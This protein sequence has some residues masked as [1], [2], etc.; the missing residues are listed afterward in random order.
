MA[1][2]SVKD[3]EQSP[4][5]GLSSTE[6]RRRLYEFGPNNIAAKYAP[7]WR[8][9]AAKFWGPIPWLLEFAILLQ[10]TLGKYIEATVIGALL[11]F[12]ATLG[13]VQEGRASTALAALRK[14]LAPM[15]PV[16]RDGEWKRLVASDVVPGD[17]IRLTLGAMIPADARLVSGSLLLDQSAI[18][19]ESVPVDVALGDP[20]HAG[21][22]VRRGEAQAEVTATGGRTAYGR[23]AELVRSARA[24]S[25]EQLAIMGVTRSLI[26]VNGCVAV[27]IVVGATMLGLPLPDLVSLALTG[28]LAS[29]PA[30]L[31]ATFT[32]SAA[33]S[34]QVLAKQGV[35]LTRLS[36]AHEAA[37]MDLLCADKTGTLTR[38]VLEV[39]EIVPMPG[40]D[41]A[42]LLALAAFASSEADQDPIDT[43]IRTAAVREAAKPDHERQLRFVPFDPVTRVAEALIAD[44]DGIES[45]VSKG[46][47]EAISSIAAVSPEALQSANELA[48]RGHRVIAVAA[49]LPGESRLCGL[50]AISDPPREE[51]ALLVGALSE[52]GVRTV[53]VT[54]DSPATATAIA[55]KVGIGGKTCPP[56]RLTAEQS[57]DAYDIFARVNPD[58]KHRLVQS[59]QRS[60]HVVGMCGDGL[61]D[62]PALRQA[63]IG[64][65][66]SSATDA[67]KSAAAMVL[68][69]PGLGGI[70]HAVHEG[71]IAFQ[72]LRTYAFNMLVK[73]TE[74]VLFLAV[75]LALTGHAVM[76]PVLMVLM[77]VTNDF[78]A[79]SLTTDRASAA[80]SPSVWRMR[81][82]AAGAVVMGGC[83]LGF[84]SSMLA[85][86]IHGLA[87][88]PE[89]LQTLAFVILVLGSQGLL[90]VVRE[91]RQLWSSR[92]SKWVLLAS[93]V[94][95]LI[96]FALASTGTLMEALSW[97]VITGVM[98][99]VIGMALILDRIKFWVLRAFR[100]E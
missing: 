18:T 67:A 94:D 39:A 93:A 81:N 42:R 62:A 26:L 79:M 58:G 32:L 78:L 98:I 99:A 5:S 34:A 31:P 72:R 80:P 85:Y 14:R 15:V 48:Q 61:N 36:A 20:I 33:F 68:T 69:Q 91:R 17:L 51:S 12:N 16:R 3:T 47:I 9:Y 71:R 24:P 90:F 97:R 65:A 19:G 7:A 2:V 8:V 28:L 49:G 38:N 11:L 43:A 35:L 23:A 46:A 77:L 89:Q 55:G 75:G 73:K 83:K 88:T 84:S 86:G 27:L 13:Y 25:T 70:V 64:I 57:I 44:G 87:L 40:F 45:R 63:Q 1:S 66:V 30:A 21:S 50:I 59:L 6:A 74:I 54:G 41:R 53:M 56:E 92:P 96:V 82:I 100:I 29:I 52:L 60:G 10:G 4:S 37:A 22:I 95:I 76:T